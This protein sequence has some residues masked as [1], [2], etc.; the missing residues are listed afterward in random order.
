MK[1]AQHYTVLI[2]CNSER[3]QWWAACSCGTFVLANSSYER[4]REHLIHV[5]QQR[6]SD[7]PEESA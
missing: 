3:Q 4:D 1:R 7:K 6:T 2:G 5:Q